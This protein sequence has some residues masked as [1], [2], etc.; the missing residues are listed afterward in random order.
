M[1]IPLRQGR[2][3]GDEASERAR[4]KDVPTQ[5]V[6]NETLVRQ[7]FGFRDPLGKYFHLGNALVLPMKLLALSETQ[8]MDGSR[9][10]GRRVWKVK[11]RFRCKPAG[12]EVRFSSKVVSRVP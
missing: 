2:L 11:R 12:T 8:S 3:F 6:V 10:T 9:C 1:G 5:V 7:L 4:T